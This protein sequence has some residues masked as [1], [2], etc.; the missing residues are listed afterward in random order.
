MIVSD[1]HQA[2]YLAAPKTATTAIHLW[3]LRSNWGYPHYHDAPPPTEA[4]RQWLSRD[5]LP[6]EKQHA[7][8]VPQ[9]A[10]QFFTWTILR[11]PIDRVESLYR[12]YLLDAIYAPHVEFPEFVNLVTSRSPSLDLFYTRTQSDWL[13]TCRLDAAIDFASI[14]IGLYRMDITLPTVALPRSNV[15]PDRTPLPW[16]ATTRV[17]VTHWSADDLRL[18][19]GAINK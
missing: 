3:L 15:A 7:T 9:Y 17:A 12:H 5:G 4:R 6:H 2:I 19:N 11:D 13:H 18:L 14:P 1:T 8:S 10:R 16:T